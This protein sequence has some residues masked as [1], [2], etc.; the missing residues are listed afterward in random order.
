M[1][2]KEAWLDPIDQAVG[3]IASELGVDED[4]VRGEIARRWEADAK[5]RYVPRP[6]DHSLCGSGCTGGHPRYCGG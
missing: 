1:E 6:G 5:R 4:Y 2:I 3:A